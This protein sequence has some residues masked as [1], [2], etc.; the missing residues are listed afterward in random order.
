VQDKSGTFLSVQYEEK[1]DADILVKTLNAVSEVI[2]NEATKSF[3][4]KYKST[5]GSNVVEGTK[6]VT[7]PDIGKAR[8]RFMEDNTELKGLQVTSVNEVR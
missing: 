5:D 3:E 6:I 4:I 7:A 1:K 2:I 8:S